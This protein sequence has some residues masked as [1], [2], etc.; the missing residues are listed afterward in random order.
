[1]KIQIRERSEKEMKVKVTKGCKARKG[2]RNKKKV[3][4]DRGKEDEKTDGK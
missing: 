1:M 3:E 4:I 2:G